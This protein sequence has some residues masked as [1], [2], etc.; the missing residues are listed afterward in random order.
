MEPLPINLRDVLLEAEQLRTEV[1][2]AC[3]DGVAIR[4]VVA[5]V[6]SDV[7]TITDGSNRHD[8]ALFHVVRV[9]W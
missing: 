8:V 1:T 2:V 3:A 7:A 4:G 6:G 5:D 9:G